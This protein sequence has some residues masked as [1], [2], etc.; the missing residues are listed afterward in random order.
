MTNAKKVFA[1]LVLAAWAASPVL[2]ETQYT[3]V[4][5]MGV[6]CGQFTALDTPTKRDVSYHILRWIHDEANAVA[7]QK[8]IGHYANGGWTEEDL[9]IDIEGH[10]KDA[11]PDTGVIDR[12]IE[13]T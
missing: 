11:T 4:D 12:L 9:T 5:V 13:H 8:L 6:T 10:C 1:G 2:A 3:P 7:A